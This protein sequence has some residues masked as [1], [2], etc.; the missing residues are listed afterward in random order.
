MKWVK[1]FLFGLLAI[2]LLG[3]G[4][5]YAWSSIIV[6]REYAAEPRNILLSSRPEIVARGKRLA[7]VFGCFFGCHGEDMEGEVFFEG[8]AVGRI[9]SPNLT[10]AV[11]EFSRT[12]LEA[13]IRQG[14]LPDGKSVFGMPSASF[15]TMSDRDLSA[16]LSFIDGY[17]KQE[18]DLGR[19]K[20]GLLPRYMLI[21]GELE[22]EAAIAKGKPLQSDSLNDP[23]ILGKYLAMNA[24]S[25]CHGMDLQG[26][27]GFS[28]AMVIV[29]GY[30]LED[31]KKLM[32]TGVGLGDRDLDL[33][34]VVAKYRFSEMTEE[35]MEALHQFLQTL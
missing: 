23:M 34:S 27:G 6:S 35:E 8:W 26:Q 14:I 32:S 4:I 30:S 9:I 16:I 18:L 19:S 24:C 17:P 10:R 31:F 29:K 20:Y 22:P 2:V 5:V 21:R 33:M 13:I 12:E 7:Q 25:E 15:A 3:T 1:R 28:P 11:D